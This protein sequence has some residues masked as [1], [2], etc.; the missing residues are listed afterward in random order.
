[1]HAIHQK[2][3]A[4]PALRPEFLAILFAVP[5]HV[6][7]FMYGIDMVKATQYI[8]KTNGEKPRSVK[9]IYNKWILRLAWERF[10]EPQFLPG[11]GVPF[12]RWT[13]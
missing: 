7:C 6:L 1:M 4:N 3:V 8:T 12:V 2:Y 11:V 5:F 10:V 13:I 9:S